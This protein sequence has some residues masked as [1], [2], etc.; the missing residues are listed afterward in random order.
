MPGAAA[1]PPA[2]IATITS[3]EAARAIAAANPA[4]AVA[5][6]TPVPARPA[7]AA[8][9]AT[10]APATG[11]SPAA[12]PTVSALGPAFR[13]DPLRPLAV[14]AP[15]SALVAPIISF[16]RLA[17]AIATERRVRIVAIG[18]STTEGVGAS[19]PAYSYPARLST[20]LGEARPDIAWSV[21]GRGIGGE[22]VAETFARFDDDVLTLRPAL[23]IW[24]IGSN[25]AMRGTDPGHFRTLVKRGVEMLNAAG[26]DVILMNPQFAPR[27]NRR[28]HL[29]R[30]TEA[31]AQI[32]VKTEAALFPRYELMRFWVETRGVP[33]SSLLVE[34]ELHHGDFGYACIAQ[35]LARMVLAGLPDSAAAPRAEATR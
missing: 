24:Q 33:L 17:A 15:P 9:P 11:P 32:A 25:A 26:A 6:A 1:D 10:A 7:I 2:G 20:E 31:L 22:D 19:S 14:C 27:L 35:A 30:F 21:Y 4:S 18:S 8:A 3:P 29:A 28:P 16:D 34:D 13:P 23:V 12:P 5:P